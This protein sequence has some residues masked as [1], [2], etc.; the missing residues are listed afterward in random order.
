[1]KAK[2]KNVEVEGT[3]TEMRELLGIAVEH[4]VKFVQNTTPKATKQH[5]T[6]TVMY[7][8]HWTHK[9]LNVL[10]DKWI[11]GLKGGKKRMLHNKRVAK[12]LG[13]TY[14]ACSQQMWLLKAKVIA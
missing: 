12:E 1:M 10:R 5:H 3:V 9:D 13:R 14:A 6:R 8:K 4:T 7:D 2:I 11:V